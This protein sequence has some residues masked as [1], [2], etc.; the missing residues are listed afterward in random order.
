MARIGTRVGDLSRLQ[1]ALG[2][3]EAALE[4]FEA[5]GASRYMAIVGN[6]CAAIRAKLA[7][8]G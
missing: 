2:L 3:A 8:G 7:D 1:E 6:R 4:V 5:A